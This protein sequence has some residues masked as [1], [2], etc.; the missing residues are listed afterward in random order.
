MPSIEQ[1]ASDIE[2]IKKRNQRVE[3][4][5]AWEI[6]WSRRC[7]ILIFTY[8]LIV[9]FFVFARLPKPF[10]SAIVPAIAY[11]LSTLSVPLFKKWWLDK[12][13]KK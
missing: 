12:M 11:V 9:I 10:L 4:D 8:I 5:K 2:E 13:Y 1:L 7:I 6:S 3:A